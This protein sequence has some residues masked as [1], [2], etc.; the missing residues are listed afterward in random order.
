M[1]QNIYS[2]QY[3]VSSVKNKAKSYNGVSY[4]LQ[5]NGEITGNIKKLLNLPIGL[6]FHVLKCVKNTKVI[7]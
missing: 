5:Y 4:F 2:K 6:N 3:F 7:T 1:S